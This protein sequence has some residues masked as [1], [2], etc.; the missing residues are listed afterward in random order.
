VVTPGLLPRRVLVEQLLEGWVERDDP[1]LSAFA[2]ELHLGQAQVDLLPG[3]VGCFAE[4]ESCE[5]EEVEGQFFAV[6]ADGC[7]DL[8]EFGVGVS[9]R[10]VVW[11][12]WELDV[13]CGV[14][15]DEP[16]PGGVAVSGAD[17]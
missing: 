13:A 5:R 8:A 7:V 17:V 4:A 3:E 12:P 11:R 1:V 2:V 16:V 6:G 10:F 15:G 9:G 14:V